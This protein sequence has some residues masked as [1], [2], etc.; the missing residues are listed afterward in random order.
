MQTK[1]RMHS[2]RTRNTR[3]SSRWVGGVCLGACWDTPPSVGLETP[4]VWV[5]RT[6][7]VWAWRPPGVGL[8]TPLMCGPIDPPGQTATSP[9][10]VGLEDHPLLA[11]PI[12]IPLGVRLETCKACWDTTLPGDLLQGMLGYHPPV[13]RMR[14]TCKNITFTN[15]VCRR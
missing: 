11:R 1:T 5:S 12:N 7:W 6:P 13:D 9:L 10:G 8:E 14:D 4:Q 3:S 15:F 2:S